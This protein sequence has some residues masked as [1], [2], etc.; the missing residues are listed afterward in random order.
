M[1]CV[2]ICQFFDQNELCLSNDDS[3]VAFIRILLL[4]FVRV[5]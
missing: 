1:L 3:Q 5:H 4:V 2:L